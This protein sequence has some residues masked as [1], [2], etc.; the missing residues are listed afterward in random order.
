[1]SKT[2]AILRATNRLHRIRELEGQVKA[3]RKD[4][5]AVKCW[6]NG[7]ALSWLL[8]ERGRLI[9]EARGAIR[10]VVDNSVVFALLA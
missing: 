9:G 2:E 4:L 1:M 8:Q 5:D 7:H 6:E 3:A 10:V